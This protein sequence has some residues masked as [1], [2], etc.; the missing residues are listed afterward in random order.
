[1]L[2]IFID[3]V[4]KPKARPRF[5]NGHAYSSPEMRNYERSVYTEFLAK[6]GL[7]KRLENS[8]KVNLVFYI[9]RPKG[10]KRPYPSV[11]PDLDNYVKAVLDA[12]NELAWRDDG[13]IVELVTRKEYREKPGI[14]LIIEE[15]RDGDKR[16]SN[17]NGL[18]G[19]RHPKGSS[20]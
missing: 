6:R 2:K 10:I 12:L 9:V 17:P 4:P 18:E 11:R 8:I 3:V 20:V 5:G 13:Q 14:D 16:I 7:Y 19:S 15:L 1:M